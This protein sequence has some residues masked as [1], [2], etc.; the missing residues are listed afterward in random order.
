M[1]QV[2]VLGAGSFGTALSVHLA[3]LGHDVR[4]W[5]RDPGL[6]R[7]MAT[8]RANPIYLPDLTFPSAV[9]PTSDLGIAVSDADLIVNAVPSHGTREVLTRVRPHLRPHATIVSATKGLEEGTLLRMSELVT[10]TLGAAHPV[11]ALSGPSFA[12]EVGRGM[13][14]AI[15]VASLDDDAVSLVQAEFRSSYLRLYGSNDVVGVEIGGALKNV[16]AIAAGVVEGM[17]IGHNAQAGLITRGL[18]EITRLAC[19][20]GAR[21]DTLAGLAGLGDLVLT[22]TGS[23]SRNRH[24]GIELA[25]GRSLDDI[26]GGMKMVAE[27]IRTTGAALALGARSGVEL[28]IATQMADVL[29]GRRDAKAALEELMLR[30][31]RA[32]TD[33]G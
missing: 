21:R 15:V 20:L 1:K 22:C 9:Q 8:R 17:G 4:V 30:P 11:A 10:A 3:R 5:A 24:V 12:A 2:A 14:T 18:A 13:P 19:A 29:A 32:E 31:Q 16:I 28:P 27:G 6:A 26:V 25:R 33:G 7:E 23:L